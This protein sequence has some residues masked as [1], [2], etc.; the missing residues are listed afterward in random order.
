M[1]VQGFPTLKII[2]AGKKIG[3]PIVEDYNGQR[4]AK[5]I[6]DAVVEKIPNHVKR[7]KDDDF[8]NWL[9]KK[10]N[11]PKA[12]LFTDKGTTSALLRALAIDY[13]GSISFAQ[14]RSRETEAVEMFG[15]LDFPTLVLLPGG[16]KDVLVYDGE[17]KKAPM[18][19]FLRQVAEPNPDPASEPET[20][21]KKPTS[22]KSS[23]DATESS[24][25]RRPEAE[26]TPPVKVDELPDLVGVDQETV[27][28]EEC[29]TP[30]SH[31]CILALLPDSDEKEPLAAMDAA[32]ALLSLGQVHK[33]H[34]RRH[35]LFPF[36]SVP[37][38][39]PHA[40]VIRDTLKL[41]EENQLE[42]IAVNAK[43]SWWRRYSGSDYGHTSI[44]AWIDAIRM[45]EGS[46]EKLPDRLIVDTRSTAAEDKKEARTDNEDQAAP[47]DTEQEPMK[48]EQF[49]DELAEEEDD[50][51][52][53]VHNEHEHNEL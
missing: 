16:D 11:S 48:F 52:Q 27:L 19:D 31:I 17:M 35:S 30:K 36:Y 37:P 41:K 32:Q 7:L 38:R 33:K 51:P 2:H 14:I 12:I 25:S 1:G 47:S 6:V 45:N 42:I 10:K 23:S 4:A 50:E 8:E 26:N 13:L 21:K 39:N 29:F 53:P 3:R 5:A 20:P 34:S 40:K 15:I 28:N 9:Q 44:E 24:S 18:I 43:R 46:R 49:P 22:A